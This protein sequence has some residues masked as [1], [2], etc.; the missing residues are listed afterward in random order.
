VSAGAS[1]VAVGCWEAAVAGAGEVVGESL[2]D[3]GGEGSGAGAGGVSAAAET[4][5]AVGGVSGTT[6][7][8]AGETGG[9]TGVS[10]T[11]GG[12][13]TTGG[14]SST[15]TAVDVVAAATIAAAS[16]AGGTPVSDQAAGTPTVP[17][18]QT[19]VVRQTRLASERCPDT[20]VYRR[21]THCGDRSS[22]KITKYSRNIE[23]RS[24]RSIRWS[25]EG[26]CGTSSASS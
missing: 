7:G 14:T 17:H 22:K 12:S 18:A 25:G 11:A 8:I 23:A 5:S 16:G 4:G 9:I 10:E 15:V 19:R 24:V 3:A 6:G 13:T 2:T 26:T 1:G 20:T 21:I